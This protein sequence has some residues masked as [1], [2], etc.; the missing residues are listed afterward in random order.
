MVEKHVAEQGRTTSLA[1]TYALVS[2]ATKRKRGGERGGGRKEIHQEGLH[3]F[4]RFA[5]I[6]NQCQL[7]DPS[8]SK[9]SRNIS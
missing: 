1:T 9:D 5:I 4:F 3:T 7:I 6:P 2:K 8:I